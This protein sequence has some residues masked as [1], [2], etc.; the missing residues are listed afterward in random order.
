MSERTGSRT[1]LTNLRRSII[2][3]TGMLPLDFLTAVYRD[4]LWSAYEQQ[5][6]ADGS[7]IYYVPT[8]TAKRIVV[9]LD[10]RISAAG[11]AAPYVHRKM[12]Q[13]IEVSDKG[14]KQLLATS[15]R[16]L[17]TKELLLLSSLLDKLDA[18][19]APPALKGAVIVGARTYTQAGEEIKP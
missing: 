14:S 5:V 12:P 15:L 9:T 19:R 3:K 17:P 7:S 10:Q 13:G 6:A 8:K 11:T 1:F 4:E 18:T 16:G 2:A